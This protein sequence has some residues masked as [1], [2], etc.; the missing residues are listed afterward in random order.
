M[1]TAVQTTNSWQGFT[2]TADD[3]AAACGVD[4]AGVRGPRNADG[5]LPVLNFMHLNPE[6][7]LV[8]HGTNVGLPFEGLHPD[9]GCYETHVTDMAGFSVS[10]HSLSFDSVFAGSVRDDSVSVVNTGTLPLNIDTVL[11]NSAHFIAAPAHGIVGAGAVERIHIKFA[12]S[13]SGI[14]A[15]RIILHHNASSLQDTVFVNGFGILVPVPVVSHHTS[16]VEFWKCCHRCFQERQR[17]CGKFRDG[18]SSDKH[19]CLDQCTVH[20]K[21]LLHDTCSLDKC[22]SYSDIFTAGYDDTNGHSCADP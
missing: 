1:S 3:F 13:D 18:D 20:F 14:Q 22:F 7:D 10:P 19:D 9:L 16:N 15:G 11:S 17:P 6:S 2:V 21:P 8:N 12:P 5:S 4:T